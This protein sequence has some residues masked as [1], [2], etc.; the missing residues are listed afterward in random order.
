MKKILIYGTSK[1]AIS[2][3]GALALHYEVQGF[4]DSNPSLKGSELFQRP[5]Y[6]SED[7]HALT[8]DLIVIASSYYQQILETLSYLGIENVINIDDLYSVM[9]L[10][11]EF[12]EGQIKHRKIEVSQIPL[13]PLQDLHIHK[14]QLIENRTK[15]LELIPSG[16]ICAELGVA[17]GDFSQQILQ[18]NQPSELN[19]IDVWQ[20]ERYNVALYNNVISK[21]ES[22]IKDGQVKIHRQYSQ[23]SVD[24]FPDEYFDWIYIDTTHAYAQTKLELEIYS[25]KVKPGGIIAG[26]DYSMGNWSSGYKYG[27][28]EAVHEFCVTHDYEIKYL[29][30]D[31]QEMQSFAIIK[32]SG[33]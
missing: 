17:N 18:I 3:L 13:V 4:I 15:L 5:V 2:H 14:T 12:I 21:F 27:V 10:Q 30:M 9:Q 6:H 23:D 25:K 33:L 1:K 11:Q 19:L 32:R 29:T 31:I 8:Y 26:H 24:N 20:C 22:Q 16:G 7:L 28:I